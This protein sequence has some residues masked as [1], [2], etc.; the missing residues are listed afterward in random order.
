MKYRHYIYIYHL[1]WDFDLSMTPHD[2]T[3]ILFKYAEGVGDL[4]RGAIG[5]LVEGVKEC[6]IWR[7]ISERLKGRSRLTK[8]ELATVK[9]CL[10]IP[11]FC[12]VHVWHKQLWNESFVQHSPILLLLHI[13]DWSQW[14]DWSIS[15][16]ES[17]MKFP[18]RPPDL[19][20]GVF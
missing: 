6:C 2:I 8:P 19:T 20:P 14:Y 4:D 18:I 16:V 15:D 13:V 9:V 11:V 1:V 12:G 5:G 17:Y 3:R 10:V 7:A